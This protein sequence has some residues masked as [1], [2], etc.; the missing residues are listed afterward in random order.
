MCA[1]FMLS[2]F[3]LQE[4]GGIAVERNEEQYDYRGQGGR[5][6]GLNTTGSEECTPLP[7]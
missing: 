6:T 1:K 2:P 7:F 5:Q 4:K 3:N